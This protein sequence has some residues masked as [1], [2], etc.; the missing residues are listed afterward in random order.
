MIMKQIINLSLSLLLF[1]WVGTS[2][3]VAAN[4]QQV[5]ETQSAQCPHAPQA[6]K[7]KKKCGFDKEKFKHELTVFITKESGMNVNE[8]RAFFPVFFEMRESM[9]HIEQQKERALRTAAKNNMAE[10]DCKRVLNE[11]QELDKKSARI[12]AQYMARLQKM[13]GARK[14]LKAIDADKRFGRRLFK[15]MTKPN[16]K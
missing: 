15:Q 7:G 8:A 1:V 12:E 4:V 5:Y 11:M 16:K 9:R 6:Y 13:I 10:R 3:S 2:I 14:L